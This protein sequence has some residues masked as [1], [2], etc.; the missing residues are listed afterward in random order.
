MKTDPPFASNAHENEIISYL[1]FD[2]SRFIRHEYER[3][4]VEAGLI[5]TPA[6]ARLLAI[7]EHYGGSNQNELA[8]VLG[9]S[10][11]SL[12]TVLDRLENSGLVRRTADKNDR[13]AKRVDT[14]EAATPVLERLKL[15][16]AEVRELARGDI[17]Q[18][19]WETFR[20]IAEKARA[21]LRDVQLSARSAA[22]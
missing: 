7:V 5:V 11:M 17:P 22:E 10:R 3:R 8:T 9:L 2:L 12:S 18:E 16:S 14:T 13:R 21:N 15:I 20:E 1:I 4:V 6:E 19:Q